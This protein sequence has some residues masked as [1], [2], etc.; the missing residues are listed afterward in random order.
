MI[1]FRE[2]AAWAVNSE[3]IEFVDLE[4][5][6]G[7]FREPLPRVDLETLPD[8]GAEMPLR[9]AIAALPGVVMQL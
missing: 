2:H 1:G 3:I 5:I 6:P 8:E 4:D 7:V 9:E